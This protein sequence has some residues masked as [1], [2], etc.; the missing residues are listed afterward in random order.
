[1]QLVYVTCRCYLAGVND[2]EPRPSDVDSVPRLL[3]EMRSR[4]V[5]SGTADTGAEDVIYLNDEMEM[6]EDLMDFGGI[7]EL[8]GSD[9][10]GFR[11]NRSEAAGSHMSGL[12][13]SGQQSSRNNSVR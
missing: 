10:C 13:Q 12:T 9:F 5:N 8:V 1:M 7:Y 6:E 4:S 2:A 11:S 3:P